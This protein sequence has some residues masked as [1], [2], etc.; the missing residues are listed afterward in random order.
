MAAPDQVLTITGLRELEQNLIQLASEYGPVNA[1]NALRTP[2]R[3]SLRVVAEIIRRNTPVDTGALRDSVGIR[4]NQA[5][6]RLRRSQNID[7]NAIIVG[8]VGWQW[9]R[10]SLWRQALSVEYGNRVT[11]AQPVIRPALNN[12]AEEAVS[13]FAPALAQSIERTASRLGRRA[14]AGTLRR[15]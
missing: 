6:S 8:R 10:P 14:R 2:V 4:V 12:L 5:S 11:Q 1:I 13:N 7:N 9:T 3:N 15:R